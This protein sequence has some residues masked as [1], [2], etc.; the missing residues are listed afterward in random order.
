M[1]SLALLGLLLCTAQLAASARPLHDKAQSSPAH[2]SGHAD[3]L[4]GGNA[5]SL[6]SEELRAAYGTTWKPAVAAG[7][8]SAAP[9]NISGTYRGAWGLGRV[10]HMY[11]CDAMC[12]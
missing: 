6:I 9:A 12:A 10:G 1:F 2:G 3:F 5:T 11:G 4:W 8:A 7:N